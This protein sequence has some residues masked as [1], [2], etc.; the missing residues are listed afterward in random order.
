MQ[1][2]TVN[3]MKVLEKRILLKDPTTDKVIETPEEMF[4]RVANCVAGSK[5][6]AKSQEYFEVLSNLLFLPNSPTLM[7]AGK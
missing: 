4:K 3:A 5:Y 2:L 7:N 1:P 6:T